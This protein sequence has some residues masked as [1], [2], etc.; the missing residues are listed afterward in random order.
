VQPIENPSTSHDLPVLYMLGPGGQLRWLSDSLNDLCG[1]SPMELS[2]QTLN[3]LVKFDGGEA[4]RAGLLMR[5]GKL[6]LSDGSMSAVNVA[7]VRR[8]GIPSFGA[9]ILASGSLDG[10]ALAAMMGQVAL[11]RLDLRSLESRSY[12]RLAESLGF[13]GSDA[14]PSG[15][16]D[17]LHPDDVGDYQTQLEAIGLGRATGIEC[18][19]RARSKDGRWL[20][21][22]TRGE[23]SKRDDTGYPIELAGV[24]FDISKQKQAEIEL[25]SHRALLRRSLRLARVAAWSYDTASSQ[26]IWTDEASELLSVP[27]GYVPDSLLGLELFDGE[28]QVR[29]QKALSRALDE[30]IGFDQ[31]LLRITPQGRVQ[32]VRAVANPEFE[33]GV[34]VRLS[35]LFQDITRQRRME[36]AVRDS[37]QLLR[38][39]TA[40]LPDA[41]FQMRRTTEGEYCLDFL[42]EGVR[43]MLGFGPNQELP[44]F[45]GLVQALGAKSVDAF[46]QSLDVAVAKSELWMQEL[47]LSSRT[48]EGGESAPRVLLGRARPESQLDGS[49]LFFGFF[50]DVTEQRRQANALKDAEQTQQRLTRLEAVGQLAGGI[51]HDFNNYLTSIVMSLSM[52]EAQP[53]LTR[54]AT[55][56]VR[57]ALSATSSAQALTRQLLTFSRGSSPV[58][59][60][61]DTE[62]LVREAVAFTLRGSAVECRVLASSSVWPIE[63]DPGQ[64]QQVIQNLVLNASQAMNGQGQLHIVIG[65]VPTGSVNL[66]GLASGP[67]VRIEVIDKGPGVPAHIREKLF[68]PYVT[69]KE[70]GSGLGLASAFSIARKHEGLITYESTSSGSAFSIWLPAVPKQESQ[71]REN[72]QEMSQGSG[73]VLVMDDNEGILKMLARALTHLGFQPTTVADGESAE[74]ALRTALEGAQPFSVVILDQ[75]IP[76][77]IGGAEALKLLRKVDPKV[78]AIATSGYTEGETMANYQDFGFDGVLR[79]PFRIQDLSRVLR[80]LQ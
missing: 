45:E 73:R 23:V 57:E 5:T 21:T 47:Q 6:R 42:S 56:L 15:W 17:Q 75:T 79:K 28:S 35:G 48:E 10:S 76:G 43:S 39:L 53:E 22:L 74:I 8:D 58:K 59:Q 70:Q 78:K 67:S 50:S 62:S 33:Q 44:E 2:G 12:G 16:L 7:E 37:E 36:Q 19:A 80:E 32:W 54:D 13:S 29:V 72:I 38:Q 51:A 11:W 64:I 69:S 24:T 9:I 52:L 14:S 66:A 63:V 49:C 25:Q 55:Q 46:R 65:N 1:I 34:L 4:L 20:W 68:Q 30:G 26:Q 18:E 71:P 61:V 40:G 27:N 3:T 60:I 77:G 31:E 41:V